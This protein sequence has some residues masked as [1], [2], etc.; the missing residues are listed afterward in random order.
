MKGIIPERQ[1]VKLMGD[2]VAE[3]NTVQDELDEAMARIKEAADRAIDVENF[4]KLLRKYSEF[5]EIDGK[6]LN[7]LFDK[8]VV[9]DP[10]MV[11]NLRRQQVDLYFNFIGNVDVTCFRTTNVSGIYEEGLEMEV[12]AKGA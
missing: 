4:T 9:H 12:K 11:N 6:M 3:Q 10:Q 2:Y 8:I 7:E 5:D 1:Y